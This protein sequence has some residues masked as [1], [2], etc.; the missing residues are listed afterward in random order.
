MWLVYLGVLQ[1]THSYKAKM[2]RDKELAKNVIINLWMKIVHASVRV[3]EDIHIRI[4]APA[5]IVLY[6]S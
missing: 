4:T 1:D 3:F 2:Q 6:I 5:A